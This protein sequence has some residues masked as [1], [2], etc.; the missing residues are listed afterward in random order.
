MHTYKKN[1]KIYAL[2]EKNVIEKLGGA[3]WMNSS[4]YKT[5][6]RDLAGSLP[7][8][9]PLLLEV[10]TCRIETI[11]TEC[12]HKNT[13]YIESVDNSHRNR[14]IPQDLTMGRLTR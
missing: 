4:Y 9:S 6:A 5:K 10:Y 14:C 1:T 12:Y 3:A 11:W 8:D 13:K 7:R 2:T